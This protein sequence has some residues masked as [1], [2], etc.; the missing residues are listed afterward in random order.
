MLEWGKR[1]PRNLH[2]LRVPSGLNPAL[3]NPYKPFLDVSVLRKNGK[4]VKTETVRREKTVSKTERARK[5][6]TARRRKTVSKTKRAR[7]L[8]RV[9]I[10]ASRHARSR[11]RSLESSSFYGTRNRDDVPMPDPYKGATRETILDG[12]PDSYRTLTQMQRGTNPIMDNRLN[13]GGRQGD[14]FVG[15]LQARLNELQNQY[16]NVKRELD[17]TASKL[18]SSMH[19]IKTFW[20]PELKKERAMRKEEAAKHALINDQIKMLRAE[21]QVG[22][23][24]LFYSSESL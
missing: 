12:L 15:E 4:K 9:D 7:S 17:V 5:T 2:G 1:R 22:L 11:D 18:G 20:S 23:T 10:A 19:S 13:Y 16:G 6:E 14:N 24:L 21:N 3:L 8:E